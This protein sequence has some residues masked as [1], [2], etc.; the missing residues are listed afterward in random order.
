MVL[1]QSKRLLRYLQTFPMIIASTATHDCVNF[2]IPLIACALYAGSNLRWFNSSKNGNI[3]MLVA[4]NA[5]LRSHHTRAHDSW[6]KLKHVSQHKISRKIPNSIP[7]KIHRFVNCMMTLNKFP[8]RCRD[9]SSI[10]PKRSKTTQHF[11]ALS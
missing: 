8:T 7:K 6:I 2:K 1:Q 9:F 3:I 10:K 5:K 11:A 4:R